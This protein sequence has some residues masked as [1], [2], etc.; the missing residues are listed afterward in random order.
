MESNKQNK[1][2]GKKRQKSYYGGS[3]HKKIWQDK[4]E[5]KK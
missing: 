3:A 4:R 2:G 5:K 1:E